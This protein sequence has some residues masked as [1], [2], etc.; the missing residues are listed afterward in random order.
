MGTLCENLSQFYTQVFEKSRF[1]Y[2]LG[3][4]IHHETHVSTHFN[5]NRS[6][7]PQAA[8]YSPKWPPADSYG[9]VTMSRSICN[10]PIHS[11]RTFFYFCICIYIYIYIL[12]YTS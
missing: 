1:A 3:Y 4:Y 11:I 10:G 7:E 9:G 8:R 12:L 2:A 5:V 6:P